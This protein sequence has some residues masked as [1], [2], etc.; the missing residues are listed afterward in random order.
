M[1][2]PLLARSAG[3]AGR[4]AG[5][6]GE[7][8]NILERPAPLVQVRHLSLVFYEPEPGGQSEHVQALIRGLP[9]GRFRVTVACGPVR[10]AW[11]NGVKAAGAEVADLR[12]GKWGGP[13]QIVHLARWFRAQRPDLVHLHGQFAG[14]WGRVAA[15]LARAP[16][17]V[18][19]PHA[20]EI[21]S[22][23][24]RPFY[25]L[26]EKGLAR[27][28]DAVIYVSEAN[29]AAALAQGWAQPGQAVVIPNGV[30]VAGLRH[31]AGAGGDP[32]PGLGL[33]PGIPLVLQGGRLHPQKGPDVLLAAARQVILRKP[34]TVFLLAGDGPQRAALEREIGALGLGAHVRI[35]GRRADVPALMAASDVVALASRWEG[36]PYAL[37]EAMALARPCVATT[38]GGCPEAIESGESGL[39]VPPEDPGALAAAILAL[40]SDRERGRA[41]GQ[42]AAQRVEERFSV[43]RTVAETVALYERL[44]AAGGSAHS[45]G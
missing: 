27:F 41:L 29:R 14:G 17:L 11:L 44:L 45:V 24:L 19:T 40:L 18:Y 43:Q 25:A 42:A 10:P 34:E 12:L 15:R 33:K 6:T 35:L 21:R 20:T 8:K 23:L 3:G 1:G 28:C 5:D 22:R 30:D 9:P 16:C 13:V 37:L 26:S 32:R 38:V 39:L 7:T 4:T 2:I 36:L 31:I